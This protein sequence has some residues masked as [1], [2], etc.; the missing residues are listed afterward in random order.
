M[1]RQGAKDAVE[2]LVP[3]LIGRFGQRVSDPQWAWRGDTM[4]FSFTA[5]GFAIKGTLEVSDTTVVVD[6]KLPLAARLFEG[7]LRSEAER[8]IDGYLSGRGDIASL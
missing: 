7:K 4:A 1:T 2:G 8:A 5:M 6:V 3:D